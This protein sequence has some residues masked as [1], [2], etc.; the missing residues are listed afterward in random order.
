MNETMNPGTL[1]DTLT[2]MAMRR[3][4]APRRS[5]GAA[6]T[7]AVQAETERRGAADSGSGREDDAGQGVSGARV[8]SRLL[9]YIDAEEPGAPVTTHLCRLRYQCMGRW[10]M[11]FYKYSDEKYESSVFMSGAATGT[12]EEA[13]DIGSLYLQ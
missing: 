11:A 3:P 7:P 8:V 4:V 13:F 10:S 9:R 6:I 1:S 12:P 5:G 2:P